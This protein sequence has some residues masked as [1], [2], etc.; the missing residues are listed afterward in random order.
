MQAQYTLNKRDSGFK[1]YFI[2]IILLPLTIILLFPYLQYYID[3]DATSY[4]TIIKRYLENDTAGAINAFWSPM[5]IWLTVLCIKLTALPHFI[6]ALIVNGLA[7]LATLLTSQYIFHHI[8][9]NKLER[10]CFAISFSLFWAYATYQQL[11]TDIWQYFFILLSMTIIFK[12]DFTSKLGLWVVLGI[13]GALAYYSKAYAFYY[14]PLMVFS[15]LFLKTKIE[16][17][18]PIK[19]ATIIFITVTLTMYVLTIPWIYLLYQKYGFIT[20]ST[21][22]NLNLSWWLIGRPI[23][24]EH[25][26]ILVPPIDDKSLFYFEDPLYSQGEFPKFWHSFPL[27]FKQMVRSAYN[28]IDWV[29]SANFMSSFYFVIWLLTLLSFFNKKLSLQNENQKIIAIVFLTFPIGYWL[30]SFQNGRYVWITIPLLLILGLIYAEKLLFPYINKI[31]KQI[32]ILILFISILPACITDIKSMAAV[33][34]EEFIIGN[35]LKELG[36]KGSFIANKAYMSDQGHFILRTAHFSGCPWYYYAENKWNNK[37]LL[38]EAKRYKVDYYFYFFNGTTDN[39]VL[40]DVNGN[41]I[42]DITHNQIKG[43]KVFPLK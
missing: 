33:G 6:A 2:S 24:P 30:I 16:K 41:K 22:G 23:Y 8:R 5:G 31:S 15:I 32:F 40:E 21:S 37:E 27:F 12:K 38:Q 7:S 26:K 36:I 13:L 43:L 1:Y 11:F 39:Y 10:I 34:K 3:P 18:V 20:S 25:I 17:N 9:T 29:K 42:E 14:F 35:Q 28:Y 19:K 4:F